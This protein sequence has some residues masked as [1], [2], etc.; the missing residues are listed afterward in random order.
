MEQTGRPGFMARISRECVFYG[1]TGYEDFRGR[2][3]K[4]LLVLD[5]HFIILVNL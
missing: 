4:H 5:N 2:Q 1:M 3:D